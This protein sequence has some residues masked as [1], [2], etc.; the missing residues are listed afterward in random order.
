MD[1]LKDYQVR[2][3]KGVY[4]KRNKINDLTGKEWLFSTR[5]V[6]T[7]DYSYFCN[8]LELL[9]S[10]N[11]DSMPIELISE[12]IT[13]FTKEKSII[14]DPNCNFGSIGF[15]TGNLGGERLFLGFN[16]KKI[17]IFDKKF[18]LHNIQ[19]SNLNLSADLNFSKLESGII[20]FSELIFSSMDY[21]LREEE[22]YKF[23]KIIKS[24]IENIMKNKI[25]LDY[26]IIAIQNTKG[27]NIYIN[28]AKKIS[29]LIRNFDYNLKAEIIW[30]I[31]DYAFANIT[32]YLDRNQFNIADKTFFLNDK[33]ILVY[34]KD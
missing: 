11:I 25:D 21:Y 20:L 30:K 22:F 12:L 3:E 26:I 13:T 7:K 16:F 18:N 8:I 33:R 31:P 4:D 2:N 32:E 15:A 19:F 29:S 6:K 9:D 23:E 10:R 27:S 34:R 1:S 24:S 28:N 14:I 17:D 5:S